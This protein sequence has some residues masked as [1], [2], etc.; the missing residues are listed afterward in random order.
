MAALY[1]S[2]EAKVFTVQF[3]LEK[4]TKRTVRYKE[5]S[6]DADSA[7]VWLVIGTLYVRKTSL[8]V[9]GDGEYPKTLTV[10]IEARTD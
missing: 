10:T 7:E 8:Y 4:E 9:L 2:K 1:K 3:E 6:N 5:V